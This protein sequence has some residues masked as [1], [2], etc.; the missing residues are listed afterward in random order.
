[1]PC[2]KQISYKSRRS[3]LEELYLMH[4]YP[5]KGSSAL[6]SFKLESGYK[7]FPKEFGE[8]WERHFVE[9]DALL[10]IHS[11]LA[12]LAFIYISTIQ[13]QFGGEGNYIV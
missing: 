3:K 4:N 5:R 6:P 1:M 2:R 12:I 7:L 10:A 8:T 11:F 13:L 9:M